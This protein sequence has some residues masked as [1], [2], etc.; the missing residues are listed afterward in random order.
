MSDGPTIL[1]PR[2]PDAVAA[3]AQSR[4][5]QE[6]AQDSE[7][8]GPEPGEGQL[9]N[10]GERVDWS[11][12]TQLY[13]R[14][15]NDPIYRPLK[16]Y[17]LDPG[18]SRLEGGLAFTKVPYEPLTPGPRGSILEVSA[19]DA[20]GTRWSEAD[21]DHASVL[22]EGGYT[23][24]MSDPR[25]HQQMVYAVGMTTYSNFKVALGRNV[26][27]A[28]KPP[29]DPASRTAF[30]ST[31]TAPRMQT[32]GTIGQRAGSCSGTSRRARR[33]GCCRWVRDMFSPRFPMT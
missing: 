12:R 2:A 11:F 33:P 19:L 30:L 5:G 10:I 18:V 6:E 16:I 14:R 28:F 7:P 32:P 9:Y 25:F 24:S 22:I 21:L 13:E 23:P 27:W 31:H 8:L 1:P 26:S 29:A 20:A 4:G 17:A 3:V 15:S